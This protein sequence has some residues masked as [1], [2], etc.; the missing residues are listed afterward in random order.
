MA[1]SNFTKLVQY[2]FIKQKIL[3]SWEHYQFFE[4]KRVS[5][6]YAGSKSGPALLTRAK[7]CGSNSPHWNWENYGIFSS[8]VYITD[9]EAEEATVR[10]ESFKE[11]IIKSYNIV[12]QLLTWKANKR[13]SKTVKRS[14][15]NKKLLLRLGQISHCW[16]NMEQDENNNINTSAIRKLLRRALRVHA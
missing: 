15:R 4:E 2:I 8:F 3:H 16:R 10:E 6:A 14:N 1:L 9:G 7:K 11:K 12:S 5:K 13:I